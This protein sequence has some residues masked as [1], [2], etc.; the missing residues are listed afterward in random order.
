MG[1]LIL[2]VGTLALLG[3][4]SSGS[5]CD[6]GENKSTS[7]SGHSSGGGGG[8]GGG[9]RGGTGESVSF[10]GLGKTK[11]PPPVNGQQ[12]V[13]G[14]NAAAAA[15]GG[16]AP[17]PPPGGGASSSSATATTASSAGSASTPPQ[18]VICGGFPNLPADC[19]RD[20]SFDAIKAKCCPTGFVEKCQG[21]P[22]GA[23]LSGSGCAAPASSI[24]SR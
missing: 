18:S 11:A 24:I 9:F 15:L 1:R 7:P 4:C 3:A 16:S 21:I 5:G 19:L 8:G 14:T 13:A 10:Q 2:I 23:R 17:N 6:G 22:G 12:A 20:P